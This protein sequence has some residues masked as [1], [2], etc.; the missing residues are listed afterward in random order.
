MVVC[1]FVFIYTLARDNAVQPQEYIIVTL[2][3]LKSKQSTNYFP[4]LFIYLCVYL[5][6]CFF[7]L[8]VWCRSG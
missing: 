2:E 3:V 8:S 5:F 1:P 6:V 4:S 7:V